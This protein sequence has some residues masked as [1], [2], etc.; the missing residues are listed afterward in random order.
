MGVGQARLPGLRDEIHHR[1][2]ET[3]VSGDFGKPVPPGT[4][5]GGP[6]SNPE[7]PFSL[8]RNPLSARLTLALAALMAGGS[9]ASAQTGVS[10]NRYQPYAPVVDIAEG[11]SWPKGQAL[12]TFATPASTLDAI[13]VQDL[14]SKDEQLTFSALQGIVNRKQP[15]IYLVDS[16]A[17]EG[18]YTWAETTT[19]NFKDRKTY[20]RANR[21]ELLAKYAKEVSGVVLYNPATSGHYRNLAFTA[22][23][24]N[25]ALPVTAEVYQ[26]MKDAHVNLKVIVDLTSLKFTT[27]L[28]IYRHLYE[29]YWPK[30]EKRVIISAKPT[31]RGDF[32]H[33]RDMAAATGAATVWLDTLVPEERE[34]LGKFFNDMKAGEAIAL[35]WYSTERSG[36]TTASAYGIGTMPADFYVS[37]TLFSGTSHSIK[38]PVVPRKPALENKVY[39]SIFVSDGDNI[40]YTQ[41]AMR[42]GWDRNASLRGKI[43]L[44]WTIAPG[45]VDIGPAIM[46]YYY[47]TATA[48]DCF[49]TGP[50]GMG[51]LMPFNTLKEEGAP[52][53]EYLKDPLRMDG[54]ARM[55]ETYLQRSGLRVMTIWDDATPM[56]RQ[57]YEKHC[58]NLYGAT[59]QDFAG[60]VPSVASGV[61]NNR[62]PFEKLLISYAGSYEHISSV[63]REAIGRWDGK[64]PLFLACQADVWGQLKVDRLIALRDELQEKFPGKIEFVR[65]DHYFNLRNEANHLPFNLAM[66]ATTVV[67]ADDVTEDV[68][69]SMDGSPS[70]LWTSV[71]R[72][73]RTLGFDFGEPRKVHRYTVRHAG[74]NGM[75]PKLNTREFAL[76]A[77]VDGKIW[78]TVDVCKANKANVTDIEFTPVSARYVKLV[79]NDAGQDSIVRIADVEIYGSN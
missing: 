18:A 56:N 14:T 4:V 6:V 5:S 15:R 8:M 2:L 78:K 42:I 13:A 37:S 52:V 30:S 12:P 49:A 25:K 47:G 75:D 51:Y 40:Q 67:K 59:V 45:L 70:T 3:R 10:K 9:F 33:T 76:Q 21:Y 61:E 22:A 44:T 69:A 46:N 36:I 71:K 48:G 72:G 58:R 55:T 68:A 16:G 35:G 20:D 50:S 63:T 7:V 41:H 31:D 79:V 26:A 19:A 57:S 38:V 28:E 64:E 60:R 74:D 23:T 66:A 29:T 39:I 54:Y 11:I 32:H 65:G 27:P 53:G 17:G 34:L 24:Q 73:K 1:I 62:L 77:S 43:P